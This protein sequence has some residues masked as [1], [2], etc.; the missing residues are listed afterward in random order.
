MIYSPEKPL[1][2]AYLAALKTATGLGVFPDLVP[3]STPTPTAYILITS[4]TKNRTAV[5]KPTAN[6]NLSDNFGWLTSIVFDIQYLSPTGFSNPGAVEDIEQQVINV[7]E[8]ILVPGWAIKSRVQVQS[9][10]LPVN[11]AT[12]YINRRVLTYNHWMEKLP[13][14]N[15]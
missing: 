15:S 8:T 1:R 2:T 10:P 11:T 4:Q 3:K 7:A 9:T 5:A 14:N 12:N 13:N 6:T